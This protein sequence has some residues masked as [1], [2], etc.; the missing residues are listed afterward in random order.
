MVFSQEKNQTP[1]IRMGIEGEIWQSA[2]TALCLLA[3]DPRLGG[4]ALRAPPGE[5]RTRWLALLAQSGLVVRKMPAGIGDAALLGG[6]DLA[7]TLAAGRPMRSIG[8]LESAAG[9]VIVAAMAERMDAGTAGR[10]AAALDSG[11]LGLVALD[12]GVAPDEQAPAALL[13][14]LAFHVD[15]AEVS[16]RD[17]D[18]SGLECG[19]IAAARARLGGITAGDDMLE[20]LCGTAAALG[21]DSVRA[22][23]LALRAAR[24]AAARGGRAEVSLEDAALAARL[25]LAPRATILPSPPPPQPPDGEPPP[26][27]PAPNDA[28]P[29]PRPA[30]G[31]QA[32]EDAPAPESHK[33]P[34]QACEIILAAAQAAIPAGLLARLR[35]QDFRGK[36]KSQGRQGAVQKGGQRGR[37]VGVRAAA[38][39]PGLRLSVI[40]TL[41]AAAPWQR[42]RA[43]TSVMG[44]PGRLHLRREDFRVTRLQAR[45]RTTTIF[46]VDA[47]GSAALARL[48]EAK[49]AVELLL[50][51]CYQRR[52]QVAVV[53]FRGCGAQVLLPPTRSLVRAKRSLAGLPGGGG[54]P[55]AAAIDAGF[56]LAEAARRGGC[57]PTLVLLTDGRAN[58]TR[59]GTG[60]RA[61]AQAE[62]AAAA[63]KVRAAGMA[64]LVL[65][66]SSRP[67]PEARG[68]AACLGALYIPLP[69]VNA[70]SI[71]AATLQR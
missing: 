7:A 45:A 40:E 50:A 37:P 58:V 5:A 20:A 62:A 71:R 54:T 6:L 69:F 32:Q 25:V 8:L 39:G 63:R 33:L 43:A 18:G 14:R 53:A 21:I 17:T 48:A 49:G 47:S 56:M 26:E 24:A 29:E 22:P 9:G 35:Q 41:R 13:D 59:A 28:S 2:V 3:V 60:G 31:P 44:P 15:F 70:T 61:V 42:V 46:L 68:L 64:A 52:D 65:D 36:A 66:T 30:D 34:D 67:G 55:L 1:H 19:E 16:H 11:G 51:D 27:P 10:M 57:T 38:P 12:E 4:V 23:L